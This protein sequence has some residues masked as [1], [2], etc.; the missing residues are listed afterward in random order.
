MTANLMLMQFLGPFPKGIYSIRIN[1][2]LVF[3][4]EPE[5]NSR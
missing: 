1:A 4:A 3:H 2:A 5:G